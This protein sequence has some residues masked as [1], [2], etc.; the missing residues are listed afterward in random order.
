M[1]GGGAPL[2]TPAQFSKLH[3]DLSCIVEGFKVVRRQLLLA[4]F[5][6]LDVSKSGSI[7]PVEVL[8]QFSFAERIEA[9]EQLYSVSGRP[10]GVDPLPDNMT[11]NTFVAGYSGML[12]LRAKLPAMS[13]DLIAVDWEHASAKTQGWNS[14]EIELAMT[15]CRAIDPKTKGGVPSGAIARAFGVIKPGLASEEVDQAREKLYSDWFHARPEA[16]KER[17]KPDPDK[18]KERRPW[19]SP[20]EEFLALFAAVRRMVP[21]PPAPD[22]SLEKP[23]KVFEMPQATRTS[24]GAFLRTSSGGYVGGAPKEYQASLLAA[25]ASRTPAQIAILEGLFARSPH[26]V[27]FGRGDGGSPP[28]PHSHGTTL[29]T[30]QAL[31]K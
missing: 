1:R 22:V 29:P 15:M 26:I 20:L 28:P 12:S 9:K 21:A 30:S 6:K 5:D 2:A 13:D 16:E 11:L 3:E 31:G 7:S 23:K 10:R 25:P 14:S 24:S 18:D 17:A 8:G 27:A 19:D 4:L